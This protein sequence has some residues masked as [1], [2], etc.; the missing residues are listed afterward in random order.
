MNTVVDAAGWSYWPAPAKLN[1]FLRITGRRPDGYHE[2][3]TVFRLL[4]WGDRIGLRLRGDGQ[5]RREGDSVP[6]VA[7]ADDLVVRAAIALKKAV[8]CAQ[9]VDIRVEKHIP[10]G[11][12]FGGG[13]SDAATVLAAL[14]A[15]WGTGLGEEALAALGL[16]LGAD[17][18]VFVR[19]RNA[20]AEGVG[21]R[22]QPLDLPPAWYL[23]VDPGVHVPTADLFRSPDLTRDAAPAKIADFASG[24]VL[25]NAF[26]PVL[27]CREPAV[28]AVFQALSRVGR[29]RLTGSGSGCFVEFATRAAAEHAMAELPGQ[30]RAWVVAGAARSPLLDALETKQ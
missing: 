5:V 8:N 27:R 13:S 3:Q 15:L 29:A 10:A 11:G 21:E 2:L 18:P 12:G 28:E 14:N 25:G 26:E 24:T 1:L 20:W 30:L 7:E 19:G 22:L 4:D 23:L 16:G 17:V 9:G 6:G